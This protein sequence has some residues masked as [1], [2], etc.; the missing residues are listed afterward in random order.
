MG[1][2]VTAAAFAAGSPPFFLNILIADVVGV[3]VRD[4]AH[5][6]EAVWLQLS[7]IR[8]RELLLSFE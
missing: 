3:V 8:S 2:C 6:K 1:G 4:E 5:R 7:F